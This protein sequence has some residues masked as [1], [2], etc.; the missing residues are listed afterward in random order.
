MDIQVV[1]VFCSKFGPSTDFSFS[2]KN[3]EKQIKNEE[4]YLC[5]SAVS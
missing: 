1:L 5:N 2:F 3:K 4:F